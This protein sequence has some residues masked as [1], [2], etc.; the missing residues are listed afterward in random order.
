MIVVDLVSFAGT[1]DPEEADFF[2][3]P[4]YSACLVY[5]NF[6]L[7]PA[8]RRLVADAIQHIIL[9]EPYWNRTRGISVAVCSP[10]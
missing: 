6:G 3:V 5:K 1:L 9:N 7:F 2:F 4:V 10:C 8:Y